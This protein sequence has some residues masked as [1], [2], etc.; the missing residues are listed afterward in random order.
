MTK[1]EIKPYVPEHLEMMELNEST[2]IAVGIYGTDK[3]SKIIYGNG[4]AMT[5]F[6]D[7]KPVCI[8]GITM[9]WNGV[10]EAWA[11]MAE[12]FEKHKF[13]IH[14]NVVRFMNKEIIMNNIKRLQASAD[15]NH[16]K[17]IVWLEHLGFETE[18]RMRKYFNGH[19]YWRFARVI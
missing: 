7:G 16:S 19:D 17:A 5:G 12:G 9:M 11:L 2:K 18:G 14:R 13:F 4:P 6:V 15:I 3:F 8:A 1:K 10:G